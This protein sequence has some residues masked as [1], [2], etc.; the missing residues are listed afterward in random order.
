VQSL[1]Y[2]KDAAIDP[3]ARFL[4]GLAGAGLALIVLLAAD[5]DVSLDLNS[6]K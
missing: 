2:L 5:R 1:L 3:G 6:I 4:P